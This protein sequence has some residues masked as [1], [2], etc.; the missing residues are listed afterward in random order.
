MGGARMRLRREVRAAGSLSNGC[1]QKKSCRV[2]AASVAIAGPAPH[3]RTPGRE[4][5]WYFDQKIGDLR[6]EAART[7]VTKLTKVFR[8]SVDTVDKSYWDQAI[9]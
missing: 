8:K 6:N 4:F 2:A 9:D 5:E 1:P 7:D 3:A